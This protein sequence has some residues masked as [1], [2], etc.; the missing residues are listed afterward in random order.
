M[1]KFNEN[2]E[3]DTLKIE[4]G[5]T[6]N[7][8]KIY[9]FGLGTWKIQS[10]LDSLI[11]VVKSIDIETTKSKEFFQ[12]EQQIRAFFESRISGSR[13]EIIEIVLE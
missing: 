3:S 11:S 10:S 9:E 8:S 6:E 2:Q 4:L 12:G 7:N 5:T 1:Y 13:K